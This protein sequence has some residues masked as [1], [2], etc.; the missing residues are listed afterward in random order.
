MNYDAQ[1]AIVEEMREELDA[2]RTMPDVDLA[3][4]RLEHAAFK[5][6]Y[7]IGPDNARRVKPH[8]VPQP[9]TG[10]VITCADC[11]AEFEVAKHSRVR[12]CDACRAGVYL[13][14]G[15]VFDVAQRVEAWL[16]ASAKHA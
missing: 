15:V 10:R 2:R 14:S 12:Q 7:H 11:G 9:G 6:V 4:V 13:K 8:V 16:E 5:R 3:D 1:E